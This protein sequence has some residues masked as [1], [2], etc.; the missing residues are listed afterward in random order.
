M[1]LEP[2]LGFLW[3]R[4]FFVWLLCG[5]LLVFDDKEEPGRPG[6]GRKN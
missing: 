6:R 5:F 2:G 1:R 4:V 3:G